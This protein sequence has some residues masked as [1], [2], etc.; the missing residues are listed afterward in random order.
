MER[1][2][3]KGRCVLMDGAIILRISHSTAAA[4]APDRQRER[5]RETARHSTTA[6]G[7][8]ESCYC[9]WRKGNRETCSFE[10]YPVAQG[11]IS[12]GCMKSDASDGDKSALSDKL[13]K[14]KGKF[15][16]TFLFE[17]PSWAGTVQYKCEYF[18][19][20]KRETTMTEEKDESSAAEEKKD[21]GAFKCTDIVMLTTIICEDLKTT[22]YP[23]ILQHLGGMDVKVKKDQSNV[24][25]EIVLT[26]TSTRS[27]EE[28][29]QTVV[30]SNEWNAPPQVNRFCG[31]PLT[32]ADGINSAFK[33][34]L[35]ETLRCIRRDLLAAG[36]VDLDS[37][38]VME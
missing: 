29:Y 4:H 18:D 5:E 27:G 22:R 17:F 32:P 24:D 8:S 6:M 15:L 37:T 10:G 2:K 33:A 19:V 14:L 1:G 25:S 34:S 7:A 13:V 31:G 38:V 11:G 28:P 36:L 3:A 30:V 26:F 12:K 16:G 35:K 20:G 23:V 21:D 9:Q